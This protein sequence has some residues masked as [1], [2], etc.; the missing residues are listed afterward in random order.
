MQLTV[1]WVVTLNHASGHEATF[2]LGND[3][4]VGT[5]TTDRLRIALLARARDDFQIRRPR[6]QPLRLYC[7]TRVTGVVCEKVP[8]VAVTVTV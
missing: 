7:T 8:E 2:V 3:H 5:R 4:F 6:S 1:G